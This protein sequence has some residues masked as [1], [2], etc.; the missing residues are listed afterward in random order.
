MQERSNEKKKKNQQQQQANE[1]KHDRKSRSNEKRKKKYQQRSLFSLKR[2]QFPFG[3]SY[4]SVFDF[5]KRASGKQN[6]CVRNF[7]YS[8]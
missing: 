6:A 7:C 4:A 8:S 5:E 1:T 2:T 3:S